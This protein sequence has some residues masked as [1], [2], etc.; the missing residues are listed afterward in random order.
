MTK[1]IVETKKILFD[2]NNV[3]ARFSARH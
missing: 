1:Y 3:K 2:G